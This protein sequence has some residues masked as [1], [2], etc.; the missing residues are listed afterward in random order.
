V[1]NSSTPSLMSSEKKLKAVT[2]S[3]VSRSPTPS[4]VVPV[5]VW[6]PS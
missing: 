5:L 1:L 4:E 2:A 6:V 3:K